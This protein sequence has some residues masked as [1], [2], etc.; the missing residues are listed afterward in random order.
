[1]HSWAAQAGDH[2]TVPSVLVQDGFKVVNSFFMGENCRAGCHI[3]PC[4]GEVLPETALY[5]PQRQ[6]RLDMVETLCTSKKEARLFT[7]KGRDHVG[8][9]T[10]DL[11]N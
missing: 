3:H 4:E 2:A 7:K 1:M 9:Q 8:I 10:R 11:C 6:E 5:S